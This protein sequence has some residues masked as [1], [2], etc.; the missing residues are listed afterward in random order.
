MIDAFTTVCSCLVLGYFTIQQNYIYFVFAV[1]HF[2]LNYFVVFQIFK[3]TV[4]KQFDLKKIREHAYLR[5]KAQPCGSETK[6][7][8]TPTKQSPANKPVN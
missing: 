3:I 4:S 6:L 1:P 2:V 5:V 8:I 7:E